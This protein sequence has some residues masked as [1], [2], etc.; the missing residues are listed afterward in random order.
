MRAL[1]W[2]KFNAFHIT[3]CITLYIAMQCRL[4]R[5]ERQRLGDGNISPTEVQ[6][7]CKRLDR[8]SAHY[9]TTMHPLLHLPLSSMLNALCTMLYALYTMH[10]AQCTICT[11]QEAVTLQENSAHTLMQHYCDALHWC[12]T[13]VRS[14]LHNTLHWSKFSPHPTPLN[15]RQTRW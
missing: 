15:R 7:H 6:W 3:L 2:L 13:T 8:N 11:V 9:C 1:F 5:A 4:S 10:Y 12:S 14:V